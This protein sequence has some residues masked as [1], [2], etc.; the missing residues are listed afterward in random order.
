M[1]PEW[2]DFVRRKTPTIFLLDL[3]SEEAYDGLMK[4]RERHEEI[5]IS[6]RPGFGCWDEGVL[7]TYDNGQWVLLPKEVA[8]EKI[9]TLL[10]RA[11]MRYKQYCGDRVYKA[12]DET[13]LAELDLRIT[14][15]LGFTV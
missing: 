2:S 11:V 3:T 7:T 15:S 6:K 12:R 10:A 1:M 5:G 4:R 13:A 14:E 8:L 9:K